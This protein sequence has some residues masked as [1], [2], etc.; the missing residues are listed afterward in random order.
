[1]DYSREPRTDDVNFGMI[2]DDDEADVPQ[3]GSSVPL[4]AIAGLLLALGALLRIG[5]SI[6][7]IRHYPQGVGSPVIDTTTKL[8]Y[9]AT[10][11][12]NSDV[13]LALALA[14]GLLVVGFVISARDGLAPLERIALLVLAAVSSAVA[15][16]GI[17]ALYLEFTEEQSFNAP[18]IWSARGTLALG[19]VVHAAISTAALG[20]AQ[21]LAGIDDDDL[22]DLDALDEDGDRDDADE[23]AQTPATESAAGWSVT[24]PPERPAPS[25]TDVSPAV[26]EPAP[27]PA[28]PVAPP[29]PAPPASPP[30]PTPAP[31]ADP[32][33][34]TESREEERPSAPPEAPP[35]PPAPPVA[36]PFPQ[37]PAPGQGGQP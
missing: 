33:A 2:D 20:L 36:G 37:G 17:V 15:L 23:M 6:Y 11:A 28:A 34:T 22:D 1:M 26:T 27:A 30:A 18:F 24:P 10:N 29:T 4:S 31:L 19:V 25:A 9:V 12:P 3:V 5:G 8:R 21:R 32:S 16:L 35:A 7:D 14:L 13:A